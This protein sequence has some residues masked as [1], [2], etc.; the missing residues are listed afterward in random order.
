MTRARPQRNP[1]P[2]ADMGMRTRFV[3]TGRRTF[4]GH[5]ASASDPTRKFTV[6]IFL[7]G[8]PIKVVRADAPVPELTEARIGDGCYGFSF[9]LSDELTSES[10][11]IDARVANL[12][13]AIGVPIILDG[14]FEEQ[15]RHSGPGALRWLSGLRFSGWIAGDL[16]DAAVNIFVDGLL[17]MRVRAAAWS[18]MGAG[19]DNARAVRAFDAHLPERFGDGAVHQVDAKDDRG[20]SLEGSPL[21]FLAFAGGLDE[22]ML[23]GGVGEQNR[24][25]AELFNR[26][27]PMSTPFADYQSWRERFAVPPHGSVALRGAV[28]MVGPG[29]ADETLASLRGQ[30]DERWIAA[31]LPPTSDPMGFTSA[32]LLDFLDG[33][34][35]TC[36]FIL[37]T[38]AGSVLSSSALSRIADALDNLEDVDVVFADIDI[39]SRNGSS[40][41]LA[42]PAFDYERMLEQGYC[43]YLFALRPA[44]ARRSA[45]NGA[46]NLYR[47]F[48]GVLENGAA[49]VRRIAHLPGPL[50]TLPTL[51]VKAMGEALATASNAHLRSRGIAA[52]ATMSSASALPSCRVKRLIERPR[53]TII[54]P[55]RN[56][57]RL[58]RGCVESIRPV[59]EQMDAEIMA[60][61][62]GSSDPDALDYLAALEDAGATV[63][64]IPGPFNFARLNNYAA[65]AASGDVLCLLNND[66]KALDADWLGEMLSR[67]AEGDVGAVGAL[68]LWPS[69]VVQHGGVVLG[70]KFEAAHAFRDRMDGEPGYGD[71]LRVAR[72]CSAVTAACLTTRREDYRAV[73]GM[74]EHHFPV[75]FNDVDYCLKLRALGKRIVFTPHAKLMHLESA[76][77]GTDRH[78]DRRPRFERELRNLRAKWGDA[79]ASDPYYSPI[80]G[81]DPNPFSALASR[82][83]AM[84]ARLNAPPVPNEPPLWL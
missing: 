41:P 32:D 55:T 22:S 12:G 29:A 49:S 9:S 27:M 5:I 78:S 83:R 51:N 6:E 35:A 40:W 60:V 10:A 36:D 15:P 4:C 53:V 18:H 28:I 38:L 59:A 54:I 48:H 43:A 66:I 33:D 17:V 71:M 68:L 31:S 26:L 8:F 44:T 75:N 14:P 7:D 65:E 52:T 81:L 39:Q 46:S 23:A 21:A 79:L 24:A 56:Q 64:R 3:R 63:L 70:P 1:D 25:R 13:E 61:D 34:G 37:F 47:L 73:G 80:L 62:N 19:E 72:E 76:S 20:E 50:A 30:T 74:D 67:L 69:G 45:A 77:R 11:V 16:Q 58:L 42:F 2:L 57:P 82:P 84:A